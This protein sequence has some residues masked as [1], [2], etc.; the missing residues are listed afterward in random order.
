MNVERYVICGVTGDRSEMAEFILLRVTPYLLDTAAALLEGV[1]AMQKKVGGPLDVTKR[2][3]VVDFAPIY[4]VPEDTYPDIFEM[5]DAR[6]FDDNPI[7]LPVGFDGKK[8]AEA[9][10]ELRTELH[11][12]QVWAS[13]AIR[14]TCYPKE[15]ST[16]IESAYSLQDVFRKLTKN[17]NC[18]K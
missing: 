16:R 5:V 9:C 1:R 2:G 10:T 11:G 3:G 6:E 13:G 12:L 8:F 15:S 7:I 4:D 17:F 14:L 18:K